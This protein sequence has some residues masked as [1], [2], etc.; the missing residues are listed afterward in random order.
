MKL[1]MLDDDRDLLRALRDM[2]VQHEYVV[3]CCDNAKDALDKVAADEYDFVFVDYKMPEHDGIWFMRNAKLPR[4]T[5]ALLM[6]AYVSRDIIDKM[7]SLGA[8]GYLIKPFDEEE[9]LH[10]LSYHSLP[11]VPK[12]AYPAVDGQT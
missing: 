8:C 11:T 10:H 7:F 9:L 6:T 12:P 1:L 5:K 2:L 3:D 4:K